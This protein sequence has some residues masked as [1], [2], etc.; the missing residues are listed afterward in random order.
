MTSL[1]LVVSTFLTFVGMHVC[2]MLVTYEGV[3]PE[4][5]GQV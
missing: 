1:N 5:L 2:T 4:K 3:L